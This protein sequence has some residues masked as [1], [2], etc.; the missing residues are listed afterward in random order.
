LN[1]VDI[2][3]F[4]NAP[5]KIRLTDRVLLKNSLLGNS[6]QKYDLLQK[7]SETVAEP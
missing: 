4:E 2:L 5:N 3:Y 6:W 7:C 1:A